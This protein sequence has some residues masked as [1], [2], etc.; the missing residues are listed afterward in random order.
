MAIQDQTLVRGLLY[1]HPGG[2]RFTQDSPIMP[3]VWLAFAGEPQGPQDLI[4]TPFRGVSASKVAQNVRDYVYKYREGEYE[5]PPLANQE[6][7]RTRLASLPGRIT[8]TLYFDEL[9]RVV[10]AMTPWWSPEGTKQTGSPAG[11][12]GEAAQ[13]ER[14]SEESPPLCGFPDPTDA[15]DEEAMTAALARELEAVRKGHQDGDSA[16]D[17]GL[18]KPRPDVL[19]IVRLAGTI[20]LSETPDRPADFEKRLNQY[21]ASPDDDEANAD[22]YEAECE[23]FSRLLAESFLDIYR[24]W[25]VDT[26]PPDRRLWSVHINRDAEAAVNKSSLTVKADAARLLFETSCDKI[27]WA[28]IDSGIDCE[29]PAFIDHKKLENEPAEKKT[30][31]ERKRLPPPSRVRLT[32]DF[33]KLRDLLDPEVLTAKGDDH[34]CGEAFTPNPD[35]EAA[36]DELLE[37]LLRR[38]GKGNRNKRQLERELASLRNRICKG[39]DIDW[40][41][42]EDFIVDKEPKRPVNEHGTHVA[43]ILGADWRNGDEPVMLGICPD[44]N[45]VDARVLREDGRSDEFE[46]MAAVQY[47]RYRNSTAGYLDV[48]GANLSL[49]LRHEVAHYACG[50]TP[51]CEECDESV[52]LGMVMVAAAGNYG[53]MQYETPAGPREGYNTV[54]ITDPGNADSVITVGSTHRKRPYEYGVSYFS[55]RGPTGDGRIKPDLVAPGEKIKGPIPNGGDAYKDGTSMAAPHVSGAA[56]MLMARHKEL[57]GEP[58]RI[59]EILCETASDLGRERYFQGNGMLDILR[60]LQSI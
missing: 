1:D 46:V 18:E 15:F 16:E 21:L 54:S 51:I 19:W 33:T 4:I 7:E 32:L 49:S 43:G 57:V 41:I 24:Y 11:L 42:L 52:A 28:I 13:A 38:R 44:I 12:R 60:A 14:C 34:V 47:L 3:D 6:R 9:M 53:Y 35:L 25:P 17:Q 37:V 23:Q 39:Q 20:A 2:H 48:H 29:H 5:W 30:E 59:K 45:L 55:S 36:R 50:K 10:L 8:A 26:P 31:R 58:S 27:T 40:E 22:A 56:A